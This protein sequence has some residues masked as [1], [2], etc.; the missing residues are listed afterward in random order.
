MNIEQFQYILQSIRP[1]LLRLAIQMARENDEAEDL[2][3]EVFLRLWLSRERLINYDS[4]EFV[5]MRALKNIHID[6]FRKKKIE[7]EAIA[8]QSIKSEE[9]NPCQQ[10]ESKEQVFKLLNIIKNLP[11]LQRLIIKMKDVEGYE[12]DEIA[13]ITQSTTESVRMN[14]SR[15]RKR[16]RDMYIKHNE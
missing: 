7:Y 14:L 16:V 15:A 1:K 9:Q 4:I 6:K 10:I 11:D 8:N 12:I 5:A 2:V 3:Q 13:K